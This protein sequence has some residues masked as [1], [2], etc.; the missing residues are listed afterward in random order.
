MYEKCKISVFSYVSVIITAQHSLNRHATV[1]S[2]AEHQPCLLIGVFQ[3]QVILSAMCLCMFSVLSLCVLIWG[4]KLVS[5]FLTNGKAIKFRP[6]LL[7]YLSLSPCIPAFM[8][9]MLHHPT[10]SQLGHYDYML[11]SSV[12]VVYG[13]PSLSS[14]IS[15]WKHTHTH[16]HSFILLT[17]AGISCLVSKGR[18]WRLS[19]CFPTVSPRPW[20]FWNSILAYYF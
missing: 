9:I 6:V 17:A 13:T 16:T 4:D 12:L 8:F 11:P 14:S 1:R 2:W 10:S 15:V 18:C 20:L 19:R 7:F 5:T 3:C